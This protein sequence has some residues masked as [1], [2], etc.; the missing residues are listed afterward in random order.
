MKESC[1]LKVNMCYKLLI[2][3]ISSETILYF[4]DSFSLANLI[5]SLCL[6]LKGHIIQFKKFNI[7]SPLFILI[8]AEAYY[9]DF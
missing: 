3:Y 6:Y 2:I 1:N 8:M 5:D 9:R 4:R 7:Y